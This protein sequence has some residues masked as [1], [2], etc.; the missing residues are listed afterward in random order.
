M[1]W[2]AGVRFPAGKEIFL[3]FSAAS[4]PARVPTQ[5]PIQWVLRALFSGV[6]WPGREADHSRPS[7]AEVK[8]GGAIDPFPSTF[9][10]LSA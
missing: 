9:L 2:T 7:G 4:T 8:N 3:L 1:F 5:P 6:M 10:L